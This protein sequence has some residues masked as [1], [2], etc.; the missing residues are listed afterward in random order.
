MQDIT[1]KGWVSSSATS[2]LTYTTYEPKT[3]AGTDVDIAISHCG[4]CGSDIHTLRSGWGP[5]NY[6]CVVGHEIIGHIVRVGPDVAKLES[7][8]RE[9][10]AGDRV[11]VGAQSGSCLRVDC[12]ECSSGLDN[13]CQRMTGTYNGKYL[14]G[15]K[16]YGGYA[17]YWRG[18]AW[19]VFKIPD[20]LPSAIAAPLLCG[21]TTVFSPL[22]RGGAGPGK[23]VG[24]I[25]IGGLGHMGL[26]FA[27]AMKCDKIVAI[28]RTGSKKSDALGGLGADVFI[29]TDEEKNWARAHSRT[30]DLIIC[31]VSSGNMPIEKYLRLL[32]RGGEFI[33]VGAPED[34]FPAFRVGVMMGKGLKI[35]ASA[36]G[37]TEEIR[38]MLKLANEQRV[39]PWVQERPMDNVNQALV[40]MHEGKARYRYV[41]VNRAEGN[42]RL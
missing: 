28:S 33:Q 9:L 38:A 39:L 40:D 13:Y 19:F 7:P 26:L 24:I 2:P 17:D 14:D 25:G 6:P 8:S 30:L 1:F 10:R 16:S 3:F 12:E 34:P 5:T 27:K 32:K 22:L 31:T 4:I 20:G 42:T 21:G 23:S 36:I 18:P 37:S 15:S 41:L 29:A 11:G 35:S